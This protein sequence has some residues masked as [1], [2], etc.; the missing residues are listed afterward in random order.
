MKSFVNFKNIKYKIVDLNTRNYLRFYFILRLLWFLNTNFT[1]SII[2]HI[3]KMDMKNL[4]G[5]T[6]YYMITIEKK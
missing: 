1:K 2:K 4:K 3:V 5:E 6:G